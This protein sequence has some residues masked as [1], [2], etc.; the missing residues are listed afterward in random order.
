[1]PTPFPM[2]EPPG[3]EPKRKE[4]SSL[5]RSEIT[6]LGIM[7]LIPFVLG[8]IIVWGAVGVTGWQRPALVAQSLVLSYGGVICAYM[9]GTGA[10]GL[11]FGPQTSREPLFPAI[12]ATL[13]AWIAISHNLPFNMDIPQAWRHALVLLVLVYLLLRDLRAVDSGNLPSWYGGLRIFLTSVA[14]TCLFAIMVWLI[15]NGYS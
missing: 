2:Q 5:R 8:A 1:M 13:I 7:G 14:G 12:I 15:A 10:G 11:L 3:V 4:R 6:M 9:A